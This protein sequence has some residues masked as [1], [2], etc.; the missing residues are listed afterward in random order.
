MASFGTALAETKRILAAW[1]E[2]PKLAACTIVRDVKGAVALY[3]EEA[4]GQTLDQNAINT[5]K[6]TLSAQLGN[7][8]SGIVYTENSASHTWTA[9]LFTTV[10]EQRVPY[11][12]LTP[13]S[14]TN[15]YIIERG[16]AKKAWLKCNGQEHAAWSYDA[17]QPGVLR[18][19]PKIVTF[20]SYKGGMGRTTALVAVALE[21]IRRHRNVLMIDTDLEAPG[22]LTFFFPEGDTLGPQKGT[23]DYILEK[24]LA[25]A[26]QARMTQYI[27]QL[28]SPNYVNEGDGNL[29][30]VGSGKL[31]DDFLPK[32][33]RIDSQELVEGK[34]K[35]MLVQL[36][37]DCN[38]E[39]Q[40]LDYILLDSRA[41]FHDMAGVVTAQLPHE[42]V[43]FGKDSFQS[44]FGIQKALRTIARSQADSPMALIVD[45]SCGLNGTVEPEEKEHFRAK[46]YDVFREEYYPADDLPT[47]TAVDV[48]HDPIFIPYKPALSRD[49]PLYDEQKAEGL[50]TLLAEEPYK[51]L[52]KRIMA[53]FGDI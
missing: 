49:I 44:W 15:L 24:E 20:F 13:Q 37:N 16:I 28:T 4:T 50:C 27:A 3:F 10:R 32:L 11:G 29:Y 14:N 17:T 45:S 25:P 40:N 6:T 1:P 12:M 42:T 41:G 31:D 48:A 22:L 51:K 47:M 5:L 18:K 52:A 9:D 26:S 46:A 33:A 43:L 30:L 35:S 21:L 36:L 38:A 7:F 8:F 19:M 2:N 39:L 23:V 53:D 34:V